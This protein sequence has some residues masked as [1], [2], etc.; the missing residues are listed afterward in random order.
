M[1]EQPIEFTK[2][3][4]G[5]TEGIAELNRVIRKLH[6]NIAG[7]GESVKVHS[8]NGVPTISAGVGSVYLRKDGGAGTSLYVKE[9]S[10]W[11]AK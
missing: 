11:V 9:A 3:T 1:A 7:D 8:G 5:T 10:G 2:E 4:L 6:E